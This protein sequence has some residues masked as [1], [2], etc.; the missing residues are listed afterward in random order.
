MV[1]ELKIEEILALID[2]KVPF[3]AMDEKRCFYLKIDRYVPMLATAIHDGHY[4]AE[5]RLSQCALLPD[6]RLY[7][8]DPH[9]ATFI[10]D[11]PVVFVGLDSRYYYDLNRMPSEAVYEV[12][13]GKPVWK[14]PLSDF[15]KTAA[16]GRYYRC[17]RVVH[18]LISSLEQVFVDEPL[19]VFD[20]HSYNYKRWERVVPEIN[21]GSSQIDHARWGQY[22]ERYI[23]LLSSAFDSFWVAENNTFFGKGAFLKQLMDEHS[24]CLVFATEFKKYFC[25]ELTGVVYVNKVEDT[26]NRLKSVIEK[27]LTP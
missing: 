13:W 4:L 16:M 5:D 1:A 26:S 11:C 12:A 10:K 6:E 9:T 3:E 20:I 7:E 15:Q 21:I 19:L 27:M 8:E 14:I 25:E 2:R 24:S 17:Y 18:H 23:N 22:I